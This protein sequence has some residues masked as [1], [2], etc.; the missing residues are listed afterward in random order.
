MLIGCLNHTDK[1]EGWI[2]EFQSLM[3]CKIYY[4]KLMLLFHPLHTLEKIK[5]CAKQLIS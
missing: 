5:R 1:E 3:E 2:R 4:R